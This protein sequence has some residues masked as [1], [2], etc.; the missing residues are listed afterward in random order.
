M[1]TVKTRAPDT[2]ICDRFAAR[3]LFMKME[4]SGVE[5]SIPESEAKAN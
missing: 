2:Y 3:F 1:N 4:A 5:P